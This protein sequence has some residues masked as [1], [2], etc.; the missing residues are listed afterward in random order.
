MFIRQPNRF[1]LLNWFQIPPFRYIS[2]HIQ[3]WGN[4][5][6]NLL[7]DLLIIRLSI[8]LS[9]TQ[10][11]NRKSYPSFNIDM[12]QLRQWIIIEEEVF[13]SNINHLAENDVWLICFVFALLNSKVEQSR[14]KALSIDWKYVMANKVLD[15]LDTSL[16]SI[17]ASW[18]DDV[19]V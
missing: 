18:G 14:F 6:P 9:L 8:D 19:Q 4:I 3:H 2:I 5:I 13:T 17:D 10:L 16:T 7:I 15:F 11:H 12:L 1:Y